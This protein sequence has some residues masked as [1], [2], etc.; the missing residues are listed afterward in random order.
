MY[1]SL[2]V[3]LGGFFSKEQKNLHWMSLEPVTVKKYT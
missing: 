2:H 3:F 1:S